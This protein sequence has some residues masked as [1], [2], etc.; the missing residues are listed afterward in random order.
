[1]KKRALDKAYEEIDAKY[2]DMSEE[3][4]KKEM[5]TLNKEI[6][7]KEK[8]LENLDG[9]A[10]EK[11]KKDLEKKNNRL[12][13]LEGYSKNKTQISKIIDYRGSLEAKLANVIA[14]KDD[15]K[16]AYAEAKK[17]FV[18]AS[19]LLK[20]E[21]KTMEMDQNEYN[22]LLTKK[23]NAEKEMKSQK[24]IFEKAQA[25]AKDLE[26]KIGKCNLAWRTLFT[27]KTWDDIQLRAKQ[28]KGRFTR[29]K[30]E[31]IIEE[32]IEIEDKEIKEQI[33]KNVRKI[34]EEQKEEKNLPAKVTT[35]TKIKNFFKSI[36][37][38]IKEKFGFFLEAFKYGT[39][40]HGGVGIGLE[41]LTMILADTENIRDVVAFPK[42]AS[43]YDLMSEAPNVVDEKQL[44]EL[45]IKIK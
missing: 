12:K 29:R 21:N 38:K 36:P 3:D 8:A 40:P 10:R 18:E 5:E 11:M 26:A 17:E 34:Q 23:E 4:M 24:E 30:D 41:R 27:N 28:T 2:K 44:N 39:P 43:A 22:D 37:A 16:K 14:V 45:G 19:K 13:N 9:E 42:T 15:S 32:P 20:D 7:G 25:K 1:M 35:W 33:G 6:T 31:E